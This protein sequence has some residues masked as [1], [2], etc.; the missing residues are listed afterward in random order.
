MRL[1]DTGDW[2]SE[3]ISLPE[4]VDLSEAGLNPYSDFAN[5]YAKWNVLLPMLHPRAS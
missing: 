2:A 5:S 3:Y 1:R 4:V